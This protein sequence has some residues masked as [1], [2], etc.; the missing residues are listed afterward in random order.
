MKIRVVT[1]FITA[2]AV[3]TREN[4]SRRSMDIVDT[5]DRAI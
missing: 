2:Q 1:M 3:L 4:A 5:V